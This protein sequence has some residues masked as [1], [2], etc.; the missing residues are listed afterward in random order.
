MDCFS[1]IVMCDWVVSNIVEISLLFR[2]RICPFE[3][4]FYFAH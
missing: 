2:H 1:L 4:K 3:R